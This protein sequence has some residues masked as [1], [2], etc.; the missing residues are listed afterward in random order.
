MRVVIADDESLARK[1]LRQLLATDPHVEIVAECTDGVETVNAIRKNAPDLVFLDVR[2][3]ELDGFGV[4]EKL[5]GVRLPAFVFV[6]A[7]EQFAVRAFETDAMDYILKPFTRD[8]LQA[9]IGRAMQ[10]LQGDD[11]RTPSLS[12]LLATLNARP[13]SFETLM[14][15]SAG[16]FK[17]LKI[18]EIDWISSEDN[19]AALHVNTSAHL[20]RATIRT[21]TEQLPSRVFARISRSCIVNVEHVQEIQLKSH[22][23]FLVI[24]RNGRRLDGSRNF[25]QNLPGLLGRIR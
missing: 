16:G 5:D 8:R 7:H 1:R 18:C 15:K 14:V 13:K 23:D 21:L 6:T 10:R 4:L 17:P 9:A 22:G 25:R 12:T 20:I 2:M 3:P 19:Y 24:L 11:S